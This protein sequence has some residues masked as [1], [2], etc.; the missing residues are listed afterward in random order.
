MKNFKKL[1]VALF[2][3]LLFLTV[4]NVYAD[5]I[6]GSPGTNWQ[7]WTL[8]DLN[9]NGTPYWDHSSWDGDSKNIGNCLTSG[10]CGAYNTPPGVI[11]Y[12]GNTDG[13]ADSDF[14]FQGTS[15]SNDDFTLLLELASLHDTNI[16]GWYDIDPVTKAKG[17]NHVIFNGPDGA[18]TEKTFIL[19]Q[20]YGFYFYD[21]GTGRTYYTQSEYNSD[22]L[23][24]QHFAIFKD[25]STFWMGI[26]DLPLGQSD[27]DYNDM[28]LRDPSSAQSVPEPTTLALIVIGI[29]G[30]GILRRFKI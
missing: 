12:W 9:N 30:L 25:G 4:K 19:A 22:G 28:I 27:A 13:T 11:D 18:G 17:S 29:S 7:S 26:E 10:N 2:L 20:F 24:D 21:Q 5:V 23:Q 8:S 15:G 6:I 16:F 3:F 14:Y 1:A